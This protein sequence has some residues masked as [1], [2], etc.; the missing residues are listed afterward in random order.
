MSFFGRVAS[1]RSL[2]MLDYDGTLSPF[3][4]DR[5]KASPYNGVLPRLERLTEIETV[6]LVLV[7]GRPAKEL[8]TLV[9]LRRPVEI[10]GSHGR[11]HISPSG[12]YR[13]T[14]LEPPQTET[15]DRITDRLKELGYENCIER[16]PASL[17]LHW[18]ELTLE[19]AHMLRDR[20]KALYQEDA[21]A[22]GLKLLGFDG[23][24]E[25]RSGRL[26]KGDVVTQVLD[27]SAPVPSA[28]LGDDLTDEDAFGALAGK[29]LTVLVRQEIRPSAA[30]CWLRPP[31]E[32]LDFLDTW[33]ESAERSV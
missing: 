12:V 7:T 11:E 33:I 18:R 26:T 1:G 21:Q 3:Q 25:I 23:G 32:L 4:D 31:V 27:K 14:K 20:V 5:L 30:E 24:L 28:Y 13:L 6:R 17:A 15:L 2:L 19:E 16:K 9:Q 29:G 22:T 8:I 10:W